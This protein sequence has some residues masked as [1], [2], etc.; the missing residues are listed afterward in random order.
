[1]KHLLRISL[2]IFLLAC[3]SAC[4]NPA[5]QDTAVETT[6]PTAA[7]TETEIAAEIV[8][9]PAA[10]QPALPTLP[11]TPSPS[12]T[13]E[14]T[15][16]PTPSPTPE[17]EPITFI[18]SE[19][20]PL[21]NPNDPIMQGHPFAI[22]GT[23]RSIAPLVRV[24]AEVKA[25]NGKVVRETEQ[26]F[27][28]SD[29]VTEC[30][31]LDL[32]FSK[33][34]E[35]LSENIRFDK[36]SAGSYTLELSAEDAQ[37][38]SALLASA[39]FTITSARKVR[40]LPN[41]LRGNYTTAL[42]FF[43]SPERFL[44]TYQFRSDSL[45]ITVDS[46][47]RD[48]YDAEAVVINGKTWRCHVDAVPY[49]EQAGRYMENTWIRVHGSKLDTGAVQLK[50]LVTFD[51]TIVRRFVN[52]GEFVSHHSF[53]TAVDINAH[54]PSHRDVLA[55]REKIYQEVTENLTYN[56]IVEYKGRQCYD[57]TY[58]GKASKA[59]KGVPE[60]L[61]NYF[62]Y[63]LAFYR[64]GFSWGFYYPHTC[65][66]MHFSLS[67]LSPTYFTEGPYAMRKVFTYLEDEQTTPET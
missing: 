17:P 25:P 52:S 9:T 2:S 8:L 59:A 29:A 36:L 53:G 22:D 16:E 7:V 38:H 37:G 54:S 41:N 18:A 40:L 44:F 27:S 46:E 32:T 1:M 6:V 30:H 5:R 15:E 64:A 3:L 58:T 35:C 66:A 12:P 39:D 14:P 4:G 20:L 62:L 33:E 49:F 45:K 56:G 48:K 60:P 26:T 65:D 13:L 21:P 50:D 43:G 55:N 42:A 19:D 67:E 28:E 51:G 24:R 34:I 11:P 47:W 63:E 23:V 31:L 57:F 10:S 61:L